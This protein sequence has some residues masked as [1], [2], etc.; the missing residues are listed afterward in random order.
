MENNI[1]EKKLNEIKTE[2]APLHP[3][4]SKLISFE[5][6]D[7]NMPISPHLTIYQTQLSSV[8]SVSYRFAGLFLLILTFGFFAFEF[9]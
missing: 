5:G 4:F 9:F 8:S 7:G 1:E 2:I 6:K 3:Y